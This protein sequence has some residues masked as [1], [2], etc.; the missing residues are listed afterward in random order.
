M[1]AQGRAPS[2][3][4]KVGECLYRYSSNGVY[5]GRIRVEGKE[6]KRSLQTVDPAL[7]KRKLAAFRDEQRPN[8]YRSWHGTTRRGEVSLRGRLNQNRLGSLAVP[9]R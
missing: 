3:F 8:D 7:A 1:R 4:Q 6:I 5:Y 2:A 9:I